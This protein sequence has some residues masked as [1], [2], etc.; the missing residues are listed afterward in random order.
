MNNVTIDNYSAE[1]VLQYPL[2]GFG[3]NTI[4]LLIIGDMCYDDQLAKQ[5]LNLIIVARRYDIHVLLADPGRYSFK[6]IV[7]NEI[8]DKMK[9]ICEYPIAD[10][11]YIESDFKTIQIWTT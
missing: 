10:C 2:L 4:D 7:L 1:N 11:D 9:R 3:K 6:S 8:N 5:I